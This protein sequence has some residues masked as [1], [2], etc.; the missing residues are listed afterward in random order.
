MKSQVKIASYDNKHEELAS[1]V[2]KSWDAKFQCHVDYN[3]ELIEYMINNPTTIKE[4]CIQASS[5]KNI[6]S[7]LYSR[8]KIIHYKGRVV[9]GI[10]NTLATTDVGFYGVF[11]YI[12]VKSTILKRAKEL[13]YK[14]YSGFT[15]LT[16]Q[17]NDIEKE[18]ALMN[19][20]NHGV[21]N[22]TKEFYLYKEDKFDISNDSAIS[23]KED[24]SKEELESAIDN[25]LSEF[26]DKEIDVYEIPILD[27]YLYRCENNR[28]GGAYLAENSEKSG[29]VMYK[30][31]AT[32]EGEKTKNIVI[33][34]GVFLGQFSTDDISNILKSV[35]NKFISLGVYHIY[36]PEYEHLD[37]DAIKQCHFSADKHKKISNINFTTLDKDVFLPD[38]SPLYIEYL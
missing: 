13:G 31:L 1:V 23:L 12:Q 5:D 21:V 4:L 7:F 37:F 6:V 26:T 2:K 11:P 14:F 8:E 29:L 32:V 24:I 9:R 36:I 18:F 22:R 28:F 19:R 20:L 30:R 16:I 3:S 38:P 25:I 35:V 27:D 34:D 33:I 10:L 17:N 15:E